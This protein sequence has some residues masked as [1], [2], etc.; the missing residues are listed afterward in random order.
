[1][2]HHTWKHIS[3]EDYNRLF[4]EQEGCC[5]VCGT[6]QS[7]LDKRL[8]VDHNHETGEIRGLLCHP[9]NVGLGYFRDDEYRLALAIEYLRTASTEIYLS[10][11]PIP[12]KTANDWRSLSDEDVEWISFASVSQIME[13]YS[14]GR[15]TA[16]DWKKRVG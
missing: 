7:E 1:M 16:F 6:H 9:C 12:R 11:K 14:I 13:K 15:S 2:M 3:E 8:S 4:D 10:E 5:A